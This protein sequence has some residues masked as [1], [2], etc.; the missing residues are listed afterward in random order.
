MRKKHFFFEIKHQ[1]IKQNEYDWVPEDYVF[2]LSR[3]DLS[4]SVL[5]RGAIEM[6]SDLCNSNLFPNASDEYK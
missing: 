5:V 4:K 2:A 6:F 3:Q 1:Y